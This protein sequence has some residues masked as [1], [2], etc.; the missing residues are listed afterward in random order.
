MHMHFSVDFGFTEDGLVRL[1]HG[2]SP[3][4]GRVEINLDGVWGTICDRDG[5]WGPR[6]AGVVCKQ[7]GYDYATATYNKSELLLLL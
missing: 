1:G 6:D 2:V 3:Y 5:S 7:L 4:E